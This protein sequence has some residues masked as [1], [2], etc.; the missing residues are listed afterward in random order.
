[1]FVQLVYTVSR[2]TIKGVDY[3][4]V[5]KY[6]NF[7]ELRERYGIKTKAGAYYHLRE[8][9]LPQGFYM[10]TLRLWD[11][12]E[13]DAWDAEYKTAEKRQRVSA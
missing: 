10:G 9:H 5:K 1:M 3:M 2:E 6:L 12:A 8:G 7:T 4:S 13:L 11:I